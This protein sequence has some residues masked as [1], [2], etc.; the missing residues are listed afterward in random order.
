[1]KVPNPRQGRDVRVGSYDPT[2]DLLPSAPLSNTRPRSSLSTRRDTRGLRLKTVLETS[3]SRLGSEVDEVP[4]T[5]PEPDSHG[6]SVGDSR[7]NTTL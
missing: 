6:E 7:G 1:M 5:E 2:G 4:E 3:S